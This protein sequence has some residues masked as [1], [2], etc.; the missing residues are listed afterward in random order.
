MGK[1]S[2]LT[3][4]ICLNYIDEVVTVSEDEIAAAILSLVENQKIV[5]EG[6]GATALAGI[7]FDK[8]PIKGKKVV[9]IISG[10]NI[11]VNILSRVV[12][13]GLIKAGRLT[14][15]NIEILDRPGELARVSEI[16]A[17]QGGNVV[18]VHHQRGNGGDEIKGCMLQLSLETSGFAHNEKIEQALR[19][20]GYNLI[21]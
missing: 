18:Q 6:A 3:L 9:C 11:D 19:N 5:A 21:S 13:R 16:I 2:Q 4:D 20:A 14:E 15:L 10:G 12:N 8:L 7:M 1:T 17:T